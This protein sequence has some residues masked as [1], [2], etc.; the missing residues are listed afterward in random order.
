MQIIQLY[1]LQ[2]ITITITITITRTITR[3]KTR[4]TIRKIRKNKFFLL[5]LYR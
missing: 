3:I 5:F 4:I 1:F 2:Y